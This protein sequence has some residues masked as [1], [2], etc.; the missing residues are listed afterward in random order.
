MTLVTVMSNLLGIPRIV[1]LGIEAA[2]T[3][4]GAG[5]GV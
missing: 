4:A 1:L 5:Y 3:G 2:I